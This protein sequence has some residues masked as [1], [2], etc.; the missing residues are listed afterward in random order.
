MKKKKNPI[1]STM[2]M[3]LQKEESQGKPIRYFYKITRLGE[4]H[5]QRFPRRLKQNKKN[6]FIFKMGFRMS[7]HFQNVVLF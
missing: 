4:S 3:F 1:H 7:F 5:Q 6:V 2:Y